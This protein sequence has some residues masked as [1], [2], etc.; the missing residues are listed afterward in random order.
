MRGQPLERDAAG[1]LDARAAANPRHGVAHARIRRLSSM[2][3]SALAAA[4]RRPPS[5]LCVSTSIGSPCRR[6]AHAPDGLDDAARHADVIVLDQHAVVEADAVID[7]A[8]ATHGVF[9][10]RAQRRDGLARVEHRDRA[11]PRPRRTARVKRRDARQVLQEVQ[12][13]P[14]GRRAATPR[15]PRHRGAGLARLSTRPRRRS[16]H[17]STIVGVH[18]SEH[19]AARRRA[20]RRTHGSS[21]T[22]TPR[23]P[24]SAGTI[25]S[26][27]MS[28]APRSSAIARRTR[29]RYAERDRAGS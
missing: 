14:L 3:M 11:R 9:R 10:E 8:A 15:R 28:P 23:A 27:V 4:R 29:S 6:R 13:R 16:R 12:R 18:L 25:A 17:S 24:T 19:L 22:N 20:R 7:A 26:V 2:M 1:D 21:P 5:R